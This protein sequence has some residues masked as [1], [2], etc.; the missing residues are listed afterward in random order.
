MRAYKFLDSNFGLKSLREKRLKIST[1]HDLN[2][3]FE[4]LPYELSDRNLRRALRATRDELA[5]R[6][7]ILCFSADW[8]DPVIWAHYSDKH[9]GLCLGFEIPDEQCR[10]VK[11]VPKRLPFPAG[12]V[13]GDAETLLFTKFINW[14]YEQEIRVWA[15]LNSKED[16][17]YFSYF[18]E[19][20]R[21]VKVIAGARC[22]LLENE[23]A[24]ALSPLA[25]NVV[26]I[27]ARAGFKE[28]E[29][30]KDKR[31]FPKLKN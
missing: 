4:L 2:D 23:I 11:Y 22:T 3:P 7:G 16:G 9:R 17:L 28:F 5:T 27:Q 20:F 25:E 13:L 31:G 10:R 18:G 8:K 26:V 14:K 30:V 15:A 21:L 19:A 24:Q 12:P 29:I 1:L 6:R